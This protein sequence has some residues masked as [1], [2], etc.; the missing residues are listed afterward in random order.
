VPAKFPGAAADTA[1][2]ITSALITVRAQSNFLIQDL[3][4]K[5]VNEYPANAFYE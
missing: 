5:V 2:A 3:L 1:T 4:T